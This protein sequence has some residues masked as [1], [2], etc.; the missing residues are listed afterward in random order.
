MADIKLPVKVNG[1][2]KPENNVEAL[3]S[4][5]LDAIEKQLAGAEKQN[6]NIG[7][8]LKKVNEAR[9]QTTSS[10]S[11]V[12]N[13]IHEQIERLQLEKE[14]LQLETAKLDFQ[15]REK[16]AR[17]QEEAYQ[18]HSMTLNKAALGMDFKNGN[19]NAFAATGL[20][21]ATLGAINPVIIQK[22]MPYVANTMKFLTSTTATLAKMSMN[23]L[24]G[25]FRGLGKLFGYGSGATE[26]AVEKYEKN[27]I[28]GRLDLILQELRKTKSEEKGGLG[29]VK[30]NG[31]LQKLFGVIGKALFG[32]LTAGVISYAW[33]KAFGEDGIIGNIGDY[34]G[35]WVNNDQ[36]KG[37]VLGAALGSVIGIKGSLY[38]AALGYGFVT[39]Q[40]IIN[41]WDKEKPNGNTPDNELVKH[42]PASVQEFFEKNGLTDLT[43]KGVIAGIALGSV[44]GPK[45][46]VIGGALVGG[47]TA[48]H[49]WKKKFDEE[50][51]PEN[52]TGNELVKHLGLDNFFKSDEEFE[53]TVTGATIGSFGG[54]KTAIMGGALALA[55]HKAQKAYEELFG[56]TSD[57]NNAKLGDEPEKLFGLDRGTWQNIILGAVFGAK[58][59]PVGMMIGAAL[60]FAGSK[61]FDGIKKLAKYFGSNE[62]GGGNSEDLASGATDLAVA[63]GTAAV[64]G[65]AIKKTLGSNTSK[66]VTTVEETAAKG[67]TATKAAGGM[68]AQAGTAIDFNKIKTIERS[69]LNKATNIA[70]GEI[71]AI[72]EADGSINYRKYS[73]GSNLKNINY[74]TKALNN[75]EQKALTSWLKG[76]T[77]KSWL[78][79]TFGRV[80]GVVK[81]ITGP[82]GIALMAYD[83]YKEGQDYVGNVDEIGATDAMKA[84]HQANVQT[85]NQAQEDME[86]TNDPRLSLLDKGFI[87]FGGSIDKAYKFTNSGVYIAG[88]LIKKGKNW[89]FAR[90]GEN[91]NTQISSTNGAIQQA[92]EAQLNENGIVFNDIQSLVTSDILSTPSEERN[93]QLEDALYEYVRSNPDPQNVGDLLTSLEKINNSIN[94]QTDIMGSGSQVSVVGGPYEQADT[95]E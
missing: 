90:F 43:L 16:L 71:I 49:E 5:Q 88:A 38:G 7:D 60:G 25:T 77:G 28:N 13:N 3:L 36:F 26:G 30:E 78:R 94:K 76:A 79:K 67:S 20:S 63:G 41:D 32:L 18:K 62:N 68:A 95:V 81:V 65:V 31:F 19:F 34:T 35:G 45:G 52:K 15:E 40:Q 12:S 50:N 14:K 69:A 6:K 93:Q 27:Q 66:A 89:V 64:A 33:D 4:K 84:Y 57:E 53:W 29:Q 74:T 2:I 87:W 10:T 82:A 51:P 23:I 70:E 72:K 21:A 39:I 47:I 42:L 9:V 80:G 1:K 54:A 17:R 92:I 83:S 86:A 75:T 22:F 46:A 85:W 58:K 73:K 11:S 8:F 24:T 37:I 48:I 61:A 55:I 91:N 44:F 59:G 56:E